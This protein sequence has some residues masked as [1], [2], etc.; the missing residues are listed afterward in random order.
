MTYVESG[1]NAGKSF[2]LLCVCWLDQG[3]KFMQIQQK[4]STMVGK[5]KYE[6]LIANETMF[7]L[8]NYCNFEIVILLKDL[9]KDHTIL[10]YA[11]C[12][13][14]SGSP[15]VQV[16]SIII[17]W[18]FPIWEYVRMIILSYATYRAPHFWALLTINLPHLCHQ[19]HKLL[20]CKMKPPPRLITSITS[21]RSPFCH[22]FP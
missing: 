21:M 11:P 22:A 5:Q 16:D 3:C 10:F 12:P 9:H 6:L 13:S 15:H 17:L 8:Q 4:K 14:F 18:I 20:I 19:V 7:S 2:R 1:T